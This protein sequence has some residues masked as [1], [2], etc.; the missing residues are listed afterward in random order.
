MRQL[1][2]RIGKHHDAELSKAG[3]RATQYALLWAIAQVGPLRPSRLA[4]LMMMAPSTLS[5][6]M[7]PLEAAGWIRLGTGADARTRTVFI[8]AAG[9]RKQLEAQPHW[10]AG[11]RKLHARLGLELVSQLDARIDQALERLAIAR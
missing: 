6:A 1:T 4:D 9:K 10:H 7:R 3:L 2:R 11:Q 8:T 5:R